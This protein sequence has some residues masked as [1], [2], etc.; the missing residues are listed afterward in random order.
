MY[1][2]KLLI[3]NLLNK[4]FNYFTLY[5]KDIFCYL[6][7]AHTLFTFKIKQFVDKIIYI[8]T[9]L[10]TFLFTTGTPNLFCFE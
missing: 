9:C 4:I 2:K 3:Y 1:N 5:L 7:F 10:F 8:H 6:N